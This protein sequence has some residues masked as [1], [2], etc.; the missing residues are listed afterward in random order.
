MS[1]SIIRCRQASPDGTLSNNLSL[2]KPVD[3]VDDL[4]LAARHAV[5]SILGMNAHV[6]IVLAGTQQPV[7]VI[8]NHVGLVALKNHQRNKN[9]LARIHG[10]RHVRDQRV[11]H[12]KHAEHHGRQSEQDTVRISQAAQANQSDHHADQQ[13]LEVDL[14][15]AH[16]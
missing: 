4:R 7:D 9:Q 13:V 5:G 15:V 16:R 12:H 8:G 11:Q 3:G 2:S 14:K 10:N 1:H 6:G